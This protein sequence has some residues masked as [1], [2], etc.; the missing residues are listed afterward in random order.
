MTDAAEAARVQRVAASVA[1][2]GRGSVGVLIFFG[3]RKT[4]ARTDEF[5]AYDFFLLT[6]DYSSLYRSLVA[7]GS[8][9]LSGTMLAKLEEM[10]D[11]RSGGG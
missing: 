2:A 4:Q 1:E 6:P 3:S 9:I 8:P 11:G 7:S 5:S 10:R